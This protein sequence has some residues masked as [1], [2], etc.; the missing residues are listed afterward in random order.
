M[1]YDTE[2]S[3]PNSL[4]PPIINYQAYLDKSAA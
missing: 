2:G 3:V 4:L 1:D